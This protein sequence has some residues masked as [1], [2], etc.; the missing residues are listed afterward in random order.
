M[1][2][3]GSALC[4]QTFM[5]TPV[6]FLNTHYQA[7]WLVCMWTPTLVCGMMVSKNAAFTECMTNFDMQEHSPVPGCNE[8]FSHV[9]CSKCSTEPGWDQAD[10]HSLCRAPWE[11]TR[12][13]RSSVIWALLRKDADHE[14]GAGGESAPRR[15]RSSA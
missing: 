15:S 5:Y 1:V 10:A 14:A 12:S 6:L 4:A 9:I 3:A 11:P 8:S 2:S 7:W 13:P